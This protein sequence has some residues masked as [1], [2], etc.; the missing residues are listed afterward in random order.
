VSIR[1][2]EASYFTFVLYIFINK[3]FILFYLLRLTRIVSVFKERFY[4]I[5]SYLTTKGKRETTKQKLLHCVLVFGT[6]MGDSALGFK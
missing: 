1:C 2:D 3:E 5:L 4:L 6:S